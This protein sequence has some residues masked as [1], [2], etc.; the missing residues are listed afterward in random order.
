MKVVGISLLVFTTSFGVWLWN[1]ANTSLVEIESGD[2]NTAYTMAY[3]DALELGDDSRY[4]VIN[5]TG[6]SNSLFG[7]DKNGYII[8][9]KGFPYSD[10]GVGMFAI[11]K[12]AKTL[13]FHRVVSASGDSWIMQGDGNSRPDVNLLTA[14]NYIGIAVGKKIW[15]Y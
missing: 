8:V 10:I 11:R 6:E 1:F 3:L 13:V 9:D 14:N 4:Q 2:Q 15:R 5:A 7:G 12:D